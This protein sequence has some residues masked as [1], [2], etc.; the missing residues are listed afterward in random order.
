M[1]GDG[2]LRWYFPGSLEEVPELLQ[3]SGVVPHGGGTTLLR[4]SLARLEG[5]IDLSALPLHFFKHDSE[6]I[7]IGSALSYSDVVRHL[8]EVEP[9]H[10]LA[11]ALSQAASTA[12]RNRITVGG[13]VSFFPL[14]SDLMGPL[15]ALG[16]RVAL[17][18]AEEGVYDIVDY[19]DNRQARRQSLITEIKLSRQKWLSY[20]HRETR[21][22]FDYPAFN[23]TILLNRS[24]RE[25]RDA[26][27]VIVG[28]T[29]KYRRLTA[30]EEA[31]RDSTWER[32]KRE[33]LD[34]YMDVQFSSKRL[35][36]AD[37]IRHLA[38]V[39]LERGLDRLIEC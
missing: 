27:I 16:T 8:R 14:W 24:D 7:R 35:G 25:I 15:V 17:I 34:R 39:E 32:V 26:R 22:R 36:G 5:L 12:L 19:L 18:G 21:T 31:L 6:Q 4:G 30:L 2:E 1:R 10:I 20:Y 37:Y 38:L 11:K 13:S 9:E 33:G 28:N 23:I 3:K 29:Q